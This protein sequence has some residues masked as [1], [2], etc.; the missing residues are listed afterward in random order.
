MIVRQC[1]VC[2]TCKA[3]HTLRIQVGHNSYQEH[4]FQCANC[5]EE[6]V[7]GMDCFPR[8]ASVEIRYI[9][10]AESGTAEGTVVNLSPEF[11]IASEDLHQDL[12]FPALEHME[13]LFEAQEQFGM[14]P[15]LFTSSEDFLDQTLG[16]KGFDE[17]WAV[18]KK[19]WSLAS[20]EKYDFSREQLSN[21]SSPSFKGPHQLNY[22]LFDFA[23]R[24]LLPRRYT[25]FDEAAELTASISRKFP[26]EF[27]RFR[28]YYIN[29]MHADSLSRY[30]DVF[31]EYFNRF[32]EFSQTL[33]FTQYGIEL[34]SSFS[35]SSYSFKKTKLFY[36]NTYEA[37]T[38]NIAVLACLN[39]V[40]SGRSYENFMQMDLSKYLTTNK[41]NRVNPFKDIQEFAE[42]GKCLDSTLR[43][44]SH[45]GAM[46]LMPGGK[47]IQYQ[48][49]G[50][51][52]T[53]TM[54]YRE[55]IDKCNESM[56]SVCA[57]LALELAI[58]F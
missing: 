43:N 39:N 20:R 30:F 25:L 56:L 57:L 48:S 31:G 49:G 13:R 21:Y 29:N 38:S 26:Q 55:Y 9:E 47:T 3:P 46:K 23:C 7:I 17:N 11:P 52:A 4:S 1:I 18:I 50:T 8:N 2:L 41:A 37:L 54:S 14:K 28:S 44:A 40:N 53:R 12:A 15:L 19:G 22:V 16:A 5:G 27:Q 32:S 24:F 58:A 36:G 45:H 6:V 51:G 33:I 10:N 42:I 35:A 34:P